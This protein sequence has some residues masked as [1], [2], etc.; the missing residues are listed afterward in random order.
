MVPF[1]F[2]MKCWRAFKPDSEWSARREPRGL[3]HH[4]EAARDDWVGV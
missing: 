2:L 4:L 1:R 3:W